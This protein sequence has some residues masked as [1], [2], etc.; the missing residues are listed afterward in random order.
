MSVCSL[1]LRAQ[2]GSGSQI[3]YGYVG[4]AILLLTDL[5]K[6]IIVHYAKAVNVHKELLKH[7]KLKKY[8]DG[9]A[10]LHIVGI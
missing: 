8:S 7:T 4:M 6:I 2:H 10:C 3:A 1:W 9:Y 5:N